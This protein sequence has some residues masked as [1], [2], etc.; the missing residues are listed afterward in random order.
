MAKRVDHNYHP[1]LKFNPHPNLPE[2]EPTPE[3]SHLAPKEDLQDKPNMQK[4][5]FHKI[6]PTLFD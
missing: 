4:T 6:Q 1:V 2:I 5:L 3:Y